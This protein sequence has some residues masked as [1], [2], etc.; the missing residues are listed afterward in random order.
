MAGRFLIV[1]TTQTQAGTV[2]TAIPAGLQVQMETAEFSVAT[3][4]GTPCLPAPDH[5]SLIVGHLFTRDDPPRLVTDVSALLADAINTSDGQVLIDRYWG[6]YCYVRW[7]KDGMVKA[8]MRDPSGG[9]PCYW[10]ISNRDIFA[11]SDARLLAQALPTRLAIDWLALQRHLY[12][13]DLRT[14][15]TC[16]Q[17]VTELL[18]GERVTFGPNIMTAS[19]WSPWDHTRPARPWSDKDLRKTVDDCVQ[20]WATTFDRIL[21]TISGGLDSSICTA[22]LRKAPGAVTCLTMTT[23]EAEGDERR[24]ARVLASAFDRDLIEARHEFG[25]IDLTRT[26]SAHL[27]RPVNYALGQSELAARQAVIEQQKC[28]AIFTGVGGDNVFCHMRSA[29]AVADRLRAGDVVGACSTLL[30]VCRM[31]DASLGEVAQATWARYRNDDPV[32]RWQ[33][34]DSYLKDVHPRLAV[35]HAWLQTPPGALPGQSVHIAMLLRL[36]ATTDGYDRA[37]WPLQVNPLTSQPI[38]EMCLGIPSWR[39]IEGGRDRSVARAAFADILP[40]SLINRRSKGGANSFAHQIIFRHRDLLRDHL[41][42]G[43]LAKHE[44]L[45]KRALEHILDPRRDIPFTEH[46]RLLFFAETESWARRWAQTS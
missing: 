34:N 13:Y 40:K 2:S 44:V 35:G 24:Y 41:C 27:P 28:D 37:L 12:A 45:A 38:M 32:Y 4:L 33:T 39:W 15:T 20:A 5:L 18:P 11:A 16:L 9:M 22:A 23:D 26:L 42:E 25:H 7:D 14:A 36:Q 21:Q 29:T 46:L 8:L 43:L 19:C 10:A 31:T 17:G 1:P 6:G 3:D 30:D